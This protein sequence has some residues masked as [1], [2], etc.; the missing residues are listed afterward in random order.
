MRLRAAVCVAL[1]VDTNKDRLVSLSEFMAATQK[2]EFLEKEEWEV[3]ARK[4]TTSLLLVVFRMKSS[5]CVFRKFRNN[6]CPHRLSIE[7]AITP[8]RS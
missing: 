6:F 8:K 2:D 5:F 4:G 1:Q 3:T 7:A